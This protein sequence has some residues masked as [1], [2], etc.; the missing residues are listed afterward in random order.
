MC[1]TDLIIGGLEPRFD[2]VAH[3]AIGYRRAARAV[4]AVSD[5]AIAQEESGWTPRPLQRGVLSVFQ[6]EVSS[7]FPLLEGRWVSPK[8]LWQLVY[9]TTSIAWAADLRD[10]DVE[11]AAAELK[12][13]ASGSA[14]D[15]RAWTL[16]EAERDRHVVERHDVFND[17]DSLGAAFGQ[18]E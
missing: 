6:E 10:D 2:N 17:V 15:K 8:G 16:L 4:L 1:H 11:R 9:S 5:S 12:I 3:V 14:R 7:V 13:T 18:C